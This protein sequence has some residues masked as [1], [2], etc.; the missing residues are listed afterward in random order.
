M[1]TFVKRSERT[2]SSICIKDVIKP[3]KWI[4]E[5]DNFVCGTFLGQEVR[6]SQYRNSVASELNRVKILGE[7]PWAAPLIVSSTNFP[8]INVPAGFE[9]V[10]GLISFDP[11]RNASKPGLVVT[12]K[13]GRLEVA[14]K[15]EP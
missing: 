15:I 5:T 8:R 3:V 12:V 13:D 4:L 1:I 2:V 10:T 6:C 11:N 7:K 14:E 9:G